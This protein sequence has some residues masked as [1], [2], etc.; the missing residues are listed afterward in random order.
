MLNPIVS[1]IVYAA[2]MQ[3]IS[4]FFNRISE[5]KLP[6]LKSFFIGILLFEFGS[7]INLVFQNNTWINTF[8][9]ILIQCSFGLLCFDVSWRSVICYSIKR[10]KPRSPSIYFSPPSRS[11]LVSYFFGIFPFR[12]ALALKFNICFLLSVFLYFLPPHFYS[13]LISIKFSRTMNTSA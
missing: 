5:K 13:S 9:S 11:Q 1:S 7:F 3:I 10:N 8:F 2:E 6:I 12:M 4:I